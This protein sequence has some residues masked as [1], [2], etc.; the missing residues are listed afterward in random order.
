MKKTS[1]QNFEQKLYFNVGIDDR[2]GFEPENDWVSVIE[3]IS[4]KENPAGSNPSQEE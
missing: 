4:I 1:F 3:A 2:F